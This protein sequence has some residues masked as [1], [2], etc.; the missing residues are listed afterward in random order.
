MAGRHDFVILFPFYFIGGFGSWFAGNP[1]KRKN[2]CLWSLLILPQVS[3]VL[4]FNFM[5]NMKCNFFFSHWQVIIY[6][7]ISL[8][9]RTISKLR[10]QTKTWPGFNVWGYLLLNDWF[11]TG[12]FRSFCSHKLYPWEGFSMV[13]SA[14]CCKFTDNLQWPINY[15]CT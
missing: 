6:F 13:L 14:F 5:V 3:R 11:D 2:V 4:R 1:M 12:R 15:K 7:E 10:D 8:S 9:L